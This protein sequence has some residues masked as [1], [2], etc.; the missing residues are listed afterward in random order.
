MSR[1]TFVVA[2]PC[3]YN[4]SVN[5]E[6]LGSTIWVSLDILVTAPHPALAKG[7]WVDYYV[8]PHL[9]LLSLAYSCSSLPQSR[10]SSCVHSFPDKPVSWCEYI[11]T[12]C[13][14]V[15][16]RRGRR[17]G[18]LPQPWGGGWLA[19]GQ[20]PFAL[21]GAPRLQT[22]GFTIFLYSIRLHFPKSSSL[23]STVQFKPSFHPSGFQRLGSMTWNSMLITSQRELCNSRLGSRTRQAS[24][25]KV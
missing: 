5:G 4:Y 17:M 25:S 13:L 6:A 23:F 12:G 9:S 2:F 21:P 16:L 15:Q 22:A 11:A 7:S 20:F 18:L 24:W 19:P 14:F 8:R 10:R 3:V 1:N